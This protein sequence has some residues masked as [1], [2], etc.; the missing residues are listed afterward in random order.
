[1]KLW[2]V[3]QW[4]NLDEGANGQDTNCIVRAP[5]LETAVKIAQ[6]NFEY[7]DWKDGECD[8]VF[9]MG[10]DN[11]EDDTAKI[12][13]RDWIANAFNLGGYPSWHRDLDTGKWL[14][15]EEMYGNAIRQ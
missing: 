5:D 12:V 3:A 6:N 14:T 7:L 15:A 1:M 2:H 9:L 10:E 11:I 8:V 4:G 13:I